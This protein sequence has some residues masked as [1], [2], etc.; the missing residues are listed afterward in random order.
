MMLKQNEKRNPKIGINWM[1]L[2][3]IRPIITIR[4]GEDLLFPKAFI[5]LSPKK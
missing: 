3:R 1:I 2:T 4:I 5:R